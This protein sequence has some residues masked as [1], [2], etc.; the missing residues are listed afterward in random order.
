MYIQALSTWVSEGQ[1]APAYRVVVIQ[2]VAVLVHIHQLDSVAHRHAALVG[3]LQPPDDLEQGGL[4]RPVGRGGRK[5]P[6]RVCSGFLINS[7]CSEC[8]GNVRH[9]LG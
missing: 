1:P 2:T 8:A 9:F 7:R 5:I 6:A 4:A 3:L